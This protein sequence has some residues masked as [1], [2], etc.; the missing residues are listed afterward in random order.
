MRRDARFGALCGV[1]AYVS[2]GLLP[3]FLKTLSGVP[4]VQIV[5]H[6]V[7]WSLLLLA[8]IVT[9]VRGWAA[10]R[11]AVTT[12]RSVLALGLS[13][14]LIAINWLVYIWAVTHGHVVEASLGYFINPLVNVA[15]GVIVLRERLRPVQALAVAIAVVG[16]LVL[17]L[18]G[19]SAV[20]ISGLVALSFGIYGVV[21][22]LVAV[23]A[24]AGLTIE[25]AWLAPV[26]LALLAWTAEQGTAAFGPDLRLNL[27][28]MLAGVVT[29]LPLLM[30]AAA[31]RR[32]RYATL[33]LF[34]Y[35]APT[36]QFLE[37]VWLFGE[38]LRPVHLVTFG[39]I[40][41]GC[42]LYAA[43]MFRGARAPAVLATE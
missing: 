25:T 4:T 24:L 41:T 5:A 9:A 17:A 1:G 43:D 15:L 6:R 37:A 23:D 29:A 28:L 7:L 40:W 36:L 14:V 42:A 21:R 39:C 8:A 18:S 3:L 20:W 10:I 38:P 12:P 11:A 19:G 34:Q 33:G 35:V 16:V 13:A 32:M 31:A 27:L 22:K 26:A 2:W 30:F